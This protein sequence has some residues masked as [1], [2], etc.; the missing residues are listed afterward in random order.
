MKVKKVSIDTDICGSAEEG[1]QE[2]YIR[3]MFTD[4]TTSLTKRVLPWQL[5]EHGDKVRVTFEKIED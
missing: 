3:W 2:T 1:G 4:Y 5:F